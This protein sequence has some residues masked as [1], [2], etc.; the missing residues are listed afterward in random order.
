MIFGALIHTRSIKQ[1][2]IFVFTWITMLWWPILRSLC[3]LNWIYGISVATNLAVRMTILAI[4]SILFY[5]PL[6]SFTLLFDY[7]ISIVKKITF[8]AFMTISSAFWA[9]GTSFFTIYTLVVLLEGTLGTRAGLDTSWLI[10]YQKPPSFAWL[11]LRFVNT[12]TRLARILA[13]YRRLKILLLSINLIQKSLILE[14][15]NLKG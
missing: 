15:W 1:N 2:F 4:F 14:G 3:I 5:H 13:W 12:L 11:A 9:F 6:E 8:L 7:A 10:F